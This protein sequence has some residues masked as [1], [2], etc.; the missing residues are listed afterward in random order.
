MERNQRNLAPLASTEFGIHQ[1][2]NL[3]ALSLNS[4]LLLLLQ[5]ML[6]AR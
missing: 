3:E 5:Q 6:F 1:E 2:N 4:I